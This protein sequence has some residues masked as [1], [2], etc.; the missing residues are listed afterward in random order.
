[1]TSSSY[2]SEVASAYEEMAD[3]TFD[4]QRGAILRMQSREGSEEDQRLHRIAED[5]DGGSRQSLA[6]SGVGGG[7]VGSCHSAKSEQWWTS[8]TCSDTICTF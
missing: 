7:R 6:S 1:M 2:L 3:S 8:L 5:G 4:A